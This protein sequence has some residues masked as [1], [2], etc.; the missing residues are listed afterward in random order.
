MKENEY[1][2]GLVEE[3]YAILLLE[4]HNKLLLASPKTVCERQMEITK[5]L[6]SHFRGRLPLTSTIHD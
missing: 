4:Y 2:L 6:M 1:H 5:L 3:M